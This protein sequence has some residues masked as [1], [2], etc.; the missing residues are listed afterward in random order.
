MSQSHSR[1]EIRL[2]HLR[3]NLREI[4]RCTRSAGAGVLAVVKAD[5]YGHGMREIARALERE[6]VRFF[7]VANIDEAIELR[8]ACPRARILVLGAPATAEAARY[9]RARVTPTISDAEEAL[10]FERAARKAR[11]TLAVHV[12]IDTGMGR[13]GVW[14][15]DAAPFF[16][17]LRGCRHLEVEGVYTHFS[18][19]DARHRAH[20]YAQAKRLAAAL[21]T[22]RRYGFRPRYV[23]ASNSM[24][25]SRFP[26][27]HFD[28]VRPGIVLYGIDPAP[29]HRLS[30]KLKPVM[31]LKTRVSFVK[32]AGPGRTISYGA[33]HRVRRRT[34]IATLPF[35]YSHGYRVAL[36]SKAH[37]LIGGRRCPVIG[38]V[39]M[40]QTLVDLGPRA[41][42]RRGD[43]AVL[44]G[45]QGRSEVRAEELARLAGTIPYEIVCSVHPRIP[46]TYKG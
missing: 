26:H 25:L 16:D 15:E 27:L 35:G 40:D 2:D 14:H 9:I 23:H 30:G 33:R 46:R 1:A 13:L 20:T 17:K 18:R 41:K 22:A 42:V 11:R 29:G 6:G 12:K 21:G 44:I 38:R 34:T 43:E 31:R 8:R 10:F 19:A 32:S 45:R 39:T 7:G 28:L 24:G 3:H 37:V 36:S 5:A 4:R